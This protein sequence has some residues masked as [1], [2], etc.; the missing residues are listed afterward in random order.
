MKIKDLM[1]QLEEI[2]EIIAW[3]DI[4]DLKLTDNTRERIMIDFDDIFEK[5]N[6]NEEE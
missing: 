5:L 4:E 6:E 3:N 2:R 1:K